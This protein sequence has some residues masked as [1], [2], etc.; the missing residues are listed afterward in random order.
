MEKDVVLGVGDLVRTGTAELELSSTKRMDD[1]GLAPAIDEAA[2]SFEDGVLGVEV[3]EPFGVAA[4]EVCSEL[5]VGR[6]V[7]GI[8]I[9]EET[10]HAVDH[11][12]DELEILRASGIG[13]AVAFEKLIA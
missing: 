9:F 13:R 4:G 2:P 11:A 5:L 12:A 8:E 7:A 1:V 6:D 3:L 10:M